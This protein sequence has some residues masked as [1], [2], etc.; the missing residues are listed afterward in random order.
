MGVYFFTTRSLVIKNKNKTLWR[1]LQI[2]DAKM[3]IVYLPAL[4]F[5]V[6]CFWNDTRARPNYL[7]ANR[8]NSRARMGTLKFS[9]PLSTSLSSSYKP[10]KHSINTTKRD[11]VFKIEFQLFIEQFW[12]IY[13]HRVAARI[14]EILK[15]EHVFRNRKRSEQNFN[16][17]K[18]GSNNFFHSLTSSSGSSY[19]KKKKKLRETLQRRN[20]T[21]INQPP[22]VEPIRCGLKFVFLALLE[23]GK[24]PN[25]HHALLE[26]L[27]V[28]V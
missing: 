12:R 15:K 9:L 1:N 25:P 19:T 27:S 26:P 5:H 8:S 7:D 4:R 2:I 18:T 16:A 28:V 10:P 6:H 3:S 23:H 14:D 11:A 21:V 24:S 13:N 20:P 17:R 22:G